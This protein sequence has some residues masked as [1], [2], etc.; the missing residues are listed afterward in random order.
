MKRIAIFIVALLLITSA[1]AQKK[2]PDFT[3]RLKGVDKE[4]QEVMDVMQA[5]SASSTV[6]IWFVFCLFIFQIFY[7]LQSPVLQ[8]AHVPFRQAQHFGRLRVA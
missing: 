8:Y 5:A 4:L 3:K 2:T 7:F 1:F 6:L